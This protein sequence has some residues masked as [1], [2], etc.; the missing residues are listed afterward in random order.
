[1]S[2]LFLVKHEASCTEL[3][4]DQGPTAPDEAQSSQRRTFVCV[5]VR[6]SYKRQNVLCKEVK[7]G[8]T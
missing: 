3:K 7:A 8:L 6:Q 4:E 5:C 1:M 2:I